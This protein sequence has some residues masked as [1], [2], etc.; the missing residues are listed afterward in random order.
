MKTSPRR[1]PGGSLGS[2]INLFLFGDYY[3][4]FLD[5]YFITNRKH[6]ECLHCISLAHLLLFALKS[7][8]LMVTEQKGQLLVT[9]RRRY[10]NSCSLLAKKKKNYNSKKIRKTE[11]DGVQ[12][13]FPWE[14]LAS[15]TSKNWVRLSQT[16][17]NDL[18]TRQKGIWILKKKKRGRSLCC[19]AE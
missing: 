4:D 5:Y 7:Q 2:K 10:M 11:N 19:Q 1:Q 9:R 6:F 16:E 18:R 3:S 14:I 12:T 15:L 13:K 8:T 17:R